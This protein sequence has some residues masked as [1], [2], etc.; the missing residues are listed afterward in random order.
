MTNY[1]ITGYHGEP[2]V[3]AE[4]D[5]GFNASVFG[6]GRFVLPV[7]ERLRAEYIGN[8]T[9]RIYDGK[10][11]TGGAM[12]GIPAGK[13]V[14]LLIP[15]AV[16][17]RNRNDLIVFQYRKDASTLV[18][19]GEFVVVSGEETSGVAADPELTQQDLLTDEATLDQMA[20]YRIPVTGAVISDP[21]RLFD[22]A[23][24]G[25]GFDL[26]WKNA[27]PAS[28]FES[29]T[30]PLD[31][32]ITRYSMIVVGF[33]WSNGADDVNLH[34][35]VLPNSMETPARSYAVLHSGVMTATRF[36]MVYSG[37]VGLHINS[38]GCT[39]LISATNG[40][41]NATGTTDNKYVIPVIAYGVKGAINE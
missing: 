29:Q 10:L 1:L 30:I 11:M 27:S 22:V 7:G 21:V 13:Y 6:G 26:L 3:T 35:V 2:H 12:G 34:W 24:I 33:K 39:K 41:V 14:D 15:E 36:F 8:N 31:V 4:N 40:A 23:I 38:A 37:P 25:S 18:E 19:S 20:L 16:Q 9:V 5:R 17:G 28:S 32:D